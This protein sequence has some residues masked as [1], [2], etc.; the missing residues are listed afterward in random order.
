MDLKD[1]K[2][3]REIKEI[4]EIQG[5][6][7]LQGS[8][9][10]KGDKGDTGATGPAGNL[11]NNFP[12]IFGSRGEEYVWGFE[13][14][15]V[16]GAQTTVG[17]AFGELRLTD[18]KIITNQTTFNDNE[19]ITKRHFKNSLK[20]IIEGINVN[21]LQIEE[22][23]DTFDWGTFARPADDSDIV[24]TKTISKKYSKTAILSTTI[25]TLPTSL[26]TI[27]VINGSS[28]YPKLTVELKSQTNTTN[29]FEFVIISSHFHPLTTTF[30]ITQVNLYYN[31]NRIRSMNWGIKKSFG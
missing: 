21:E 18:T 30:N 1:K 5:P 24:F 10:D 2:E 17:W 31:Q 15:Q 8:K 23:F 14:D 20:E 12:Y 9:G 22:L 26:N 6:R 29:T 19:L 16:E 4:K 13:D 3:T 28:T 25:Y 27:V 7:G 11:N